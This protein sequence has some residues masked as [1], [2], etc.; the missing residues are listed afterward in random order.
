MIEPQK[1]AALVARENEARPLDN[2][3]MYDDFDDEYVEPEIEEEQ[4]DELGLDDEIT[5]EEID[6]IAE[7]IEAGNGNPEL[8]DLAEELAEAVDEEGEA[9]ANPPAWAKSKAIWR[10][11]KKAVDPSG[12][13]AG[14]YS[15]PWAT[16]AHVYKKMGG[17]VG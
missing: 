11:A 3:D 1:L 5:A 10:K 4:P 6:D 13:G 16:V 2:P 8:M 15:D 7:M 12:K 14:K 9:M 17:L